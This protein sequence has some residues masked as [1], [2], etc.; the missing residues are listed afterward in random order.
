MKAGFTYV[1]S[2]DNRSLIGFILLF[3]KQET[4]WIEMLAVERKHQ[5]KGLGSILLSKAQRYSKK[6]Y[7]I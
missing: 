4:L 6:Q 3:I 5:S 2:K 7:S 1:I